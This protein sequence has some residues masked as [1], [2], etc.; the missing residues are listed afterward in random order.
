[1]SQRP[2]SSSSPPRCTRRP[3]ARCRASVSW[4]RSCARPPSSPP[5][6]QSLGVAVPGPFD[7]ERGISLVRHKLLELHGVDLRSELAAALGFAPSSIRFLNDAAAF[8][9]GEWW[10]GAARGHRRAVGITLGT[11]LG[12]AFLDAG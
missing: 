5:G 6:A 9:L 8:A 4:P 7:Y 1:M 2:A 12:S 10:V 3:G 11:G